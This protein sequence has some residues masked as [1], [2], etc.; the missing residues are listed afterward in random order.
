MWHFQFPFSLI[1]LSWFTGKLASIPDNFTPKLKWQKVKWDNGKKSKGMRW[2]QLCENANANRTI[3]F[4]VDL[5]RTHKLDY[6][7][8]SCIHIVRNGES[9]SLRHTDTFMR[10]FVEII[11]LPMWVCISEGNVERIKADLVSLYFCH[12]H[13]VKLTVFALLLIEFN[14]IWCLCSFSSLRCLVAYYVLLCC[15]VW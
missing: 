2:R 15:T 7:Q 1:Y 12:F 9:N 6:I 5:I 3:Q 14:W 8:F 10:Y 11:T 13:D 4:N